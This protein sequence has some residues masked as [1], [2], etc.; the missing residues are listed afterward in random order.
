MIESR[1]FV[2]DFEYQSE[3]VELVQ[4][5]LCSS[6]EACRTVMSLNNYAC[7]IFECVV[8]V[9]PL[10]STT[11]TTTLSSL[12]TPLK[13]T[14]PEAN[15]EPYPEQITCFHGIYTREKK[16]EPTTCVQLDFSN[17]CDLCNGC[18]QEVELNGP[19]ICEIWSYQPVKNPMLPYIVS[20]G[21]LGSKSA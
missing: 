10:T 21:V 16:F 5:E 1:C 2:V 12:S 4:P 9:T 8:P 15:F 7:P 3:C 11:T 20:I 14:L 6:K 18:N 19:R 13:K 17:F